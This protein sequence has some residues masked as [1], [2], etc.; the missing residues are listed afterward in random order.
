GDLRFVLGSVDTREAEAGRDDARIAPGRTLGARPRPAR[1]EKSPLD[2]GGDGLAEGF[3]ADVVEVAAGAEAAGEHVAA[4][5]G[6]GARAALVR[7]TSA[8]RSG[9]ARGP[10]PTARTGRPGWST[11]AGPCRKSAEEEPS[12]M[13]ALV[14]LTLRAISEAVERL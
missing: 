3:Q 4:A 5:G 11:A 12:A 10:G 8:S 9:K 1:V 6:D 14:S 7:S 13:I 2:G